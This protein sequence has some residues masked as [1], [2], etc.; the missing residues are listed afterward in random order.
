MMLYIRKLISKVVKEER[1][2]GGSFKP[3]L[4]PRKIYGSWQKEESK[5]KKSC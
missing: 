1:A 4:K 5:I 3:I 2:K